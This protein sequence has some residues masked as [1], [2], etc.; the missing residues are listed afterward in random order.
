M[1]SDIQRQRVTH[2]QLQRERYM[3]ARREAMQEKLVS[4]RP[5]LATTFPWM[6][7]LLVAPFAVLAL[8]GALDLL[9]LVTTNSFWTATSFVMITFGVAGTVAAVMVALLDWFALPA[10]S[11][12]RSVGSW[13]VI[14]AALVVGVFLFAWIPRYGSVGDPGAQGVVLGV[15]GS[16]VALLTGW[17]LGEYLGHLKSVTV[18]AQDLGPASVS[19][20]T[21]DIAVGDP[22]GRQR[23]AN[24]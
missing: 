19:P 4:A 22:S 20:V 11:R 17:L 23:A 3:V 6:P 12:A 10:G 15:T 8:S 9:F 18:V 14:G 5:L 7:V 21:D 16:S 24:A 1:I 13:F 2:Y